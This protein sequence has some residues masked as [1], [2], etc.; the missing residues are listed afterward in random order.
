V[1][2]RRCIVEVRKWLDRRRRRQKESYSWQR[3]TGLTEHRRVELQDKIHEWRESHMVIAA[4]CHESH[5]VTAAT[6][7]ESHMVTAATCRE[8]HMVAAATCHESHMVAAA[9]YHAQ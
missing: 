3:P 9:T 7:R 4:T 6:C 8:S 2:G 5:M 1:C